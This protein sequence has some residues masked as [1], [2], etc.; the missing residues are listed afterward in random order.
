VRLVDSHCH[1]DDEQF[2]GDREAAIDRAL[3][4]GV[5]RM[6]VIGTGEGPPDLK[7]GIRMADRHTAIF[8]TVGIHPQHAT[9]ADDDQYTSVRDLLAHPKV[10]AVGEIGLDYY[11]QPFDKDLQQRVF[12]RQMEIAR[13]AGKPIVIHTRDAWDDTLA[14]LREHWDTN[15]ASCVLHCFTGAPEIAERALAAGYWLSFAGVVTYPKATLVHESARLAPLDRILI[16][17]D[18]PYLPPVPY[19]GKRNEPAY[20][21]HT[22]AKIAQLR[23][24][25]PETLAEA[26]VRNFERAFRTTP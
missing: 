13:D 15:R 26:V 7:S 20:V 9:K 1:L 24:I 4:V 23:G 25:A 14:L 11:W 8:A 17:T 10:I 22:A 2:N 19:R 16:E 18:A 6:V 5:E 12:V 3:E 21:T